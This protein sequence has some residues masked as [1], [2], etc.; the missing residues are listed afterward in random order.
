[1]PD[2]TARLWKAILE[3]LRGRI[4]ETHLALLSDQRSYVDLSQSAL[5]LAL[6]VEEARRWLRDGTLRSLCEVVPTLSGGH[7]HVSVCPVDS[8][9]PALR[10]DPSHTLDAF[11]RSPANEGAW[12]LAQKI[13]SD[14]LLPP[15][16]IV[17]CGP[18]GSGK[19]HLL[20]AIAQA[21]VERSPREPISCESASELSL[22]LVQA[23]WADDLE[24]FREGVHDCSALLLDGIETLP[25]RDGTQ[26]ELARAILARAR[27][28]RLVVLT[29][30]SRG[31]VVPP[32]G[33][34]LRAALE[35]GTLVDLA[36]PEWELCVAILMD[37]AGRWGLELSPE[38]ASFLIAR[39]GSSLAGVDA[40]L[41][42]LVTSLP[43][44]DTPAGFAAVRSALEPG[45]ANTE[46]SLPASAILGMVAHHFGLR[47]RDLAS[48]SRSPRIA[49][50]R[51]IAMYLVRRHCGLSYPEIGQ[52]FGRHHTT[53]LHACRRV[54]GHLTSNGS[55]ASAIRL[56][57]KEVESLRN[58]R[59]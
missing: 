35:R 59:G 34:G 38:A 37:R 9:R 32:L 52:R 19:S 57:E 40:L 3:A 24:H 8:P 45:A 58:E 4:P 10:R 49:M 23:L 16:P 43:E 31:G 20:D 54:K 55:V 46:P 1:L 29:L 27:Q 36:P 14:S 2:E 6:P 30:R 42:R 15:G 21:L 5:R 50:P 12:K 44:L 7:C 51:Q 56:L 28:G 39:L 41:T 48:A 17:L 26:E 22:R 11:I 33:D 13:V 18:E 25:G 47:V 53:V